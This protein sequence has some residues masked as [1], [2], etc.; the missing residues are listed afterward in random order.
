MKVWTGNRIA[1]LGNVP[2][3]DVLAEGTPD[4][5]RRSVDEI[6]RPIDDRS[7]LILSCG[8]GMP[9]R[10]P[11]ENIKALIAAVEDLTR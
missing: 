7:R 11:T 10:A 6:L 4:D 5:V 9:P 1:L 3:R 8:G 2:P